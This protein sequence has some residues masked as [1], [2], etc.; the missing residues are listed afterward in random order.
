[1]EDGI[2]LGFC[3]FIVH[4]RDWDCFHC[5]VFRVISITFAILVCIFIVYQYHKWNSKG[6]PSVHWRSMLLYSSLAGLET[7][8]AKA[9]GREFDRVTA[10]REL[11]LKM[12]GLGKEINVN[13]MIDALTQEKGSY[14]ASLLI[15]HRSELLADAS[16]ETVNNVI[17]AVQSLDFGPQL[18][19]CNVVEN[20]FGRAEAARYA[21][22][23]AEHNAT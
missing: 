19:I 23:L 8:K 9:E 18:V 13:I 4:F 17:E 2:R 16:D 20:T 11:A 6:W 12:C 7:A 1:M 22:A 14:L 21:L 15:D 3:Y 10:C 5:R